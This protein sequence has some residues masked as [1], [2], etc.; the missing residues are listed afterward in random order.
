MTSRCRR[1]TLRFSW[2]CLVAVFVL[3]IVSSVRAQEPATRQLR[4]LPL[5]D[6]ITAGIVAGGRPGSGGYRPMLTQLLAQH[7]MNAVLVGERSDFSAGMANPR[8]DGWP[9]YVIRATSPGAPGQLYGDLVKHAIVA[10]HPDVILLMLGTNDFLRYE[11]THGTYSVDKIVHSMD[12]LLGEIYETA[13]NVHVVLG[14]IVDSPKIDSCY[15]ARFDT[16]RSTC[17]P[18]THPSLK[19]LAAKY[20]AKGFAI[21]YASDL[22]HAL[23]RDLRHFP[24][25]IHPAPGAL[26]YDALAAGW[27][28]ALDDAIALDAARRTPASPKHVTASAKD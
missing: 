7:H 12:L 21:T 2:A 9:G 16:G 4:I 15:I 14:A 22:Y 5:G 18:Y 13:P 26:G 3:S 11:A 6:S 23:P 20:A 28:R 1:V 27:F 19:G 10:T 24:D 25:G 17:D 8:H